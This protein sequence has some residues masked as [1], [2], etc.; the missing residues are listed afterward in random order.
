VLSKLPDGTPMTRGGVFLIRRDADGFAADY[1]STTGIYPCFGASDPASE[2]SL[3]E[4]YRRGGM[5]KVRR[6]RR[7]VDL[8]PDACWASGP[9][10]A[11]TF[12]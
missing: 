11:L 12:E 10:W 8:A 6:L 5:E 1:K 4:A 2:A 9:G 7:A 3:G